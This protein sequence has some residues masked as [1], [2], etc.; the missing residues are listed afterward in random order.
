MYHICSHS[1]FL[2]MDCGKN[3]SDGAFVFLKDFAP[4]EPSHKWCL[5]ESDPCENDYESGQEPDPEA[6]EEAKD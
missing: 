4:D 6:E 1:N 2:A 5:E 3:A